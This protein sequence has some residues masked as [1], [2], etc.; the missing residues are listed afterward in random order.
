MIVS[1]LVSRDNMYNIKPQI[2]ANLYSDI[3]LRNK[4]IVLRKLLDENNPKILQEETINDFCS[5]NN[6]GKIAE[7]DNFIANTK[8]HSAYPNTQKYG[9][10]LPKIPISVVE[11]QNNMNTENSSYYPND[12][13]QYCTSMGA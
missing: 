12:K 5:N 1:N 7:H 3:I 4:E 2:N 11:T 13:L 9:F 6:I 10:Y 8:S